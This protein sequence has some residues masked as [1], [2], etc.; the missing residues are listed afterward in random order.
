MENQVSE[1]SLSTKSDKQ[2]RTSS[3]TVLV[4]TICWFTI[5]AEGYDLGIYGAVLPSLLEYKEWD[6][7]PAKAGVIGSYA[8]IGMLLGNIFGGTLA[9]LIGRKRMLVYSLILFS[10]TMALAAMASSPEM[11][12]LYRFIGGIGLGGVLPS[13]AA[14]T[15]EYSPLKRRSFF[16]TVMFTGYS[17]GGIFAALIAILLLQDLGWRI[18]FWFGVIPL[19]VVPFIIKF[20]PESIGFLLSNNRQREAEEI[21]NR[22]GIDLHSILEE[23]EKQEG[24][25]KSKINSVKSLFS[26]KYLHATVLFGIVYF[27]SLLMVYGLITWLPKLMNQ[28]GYS[29]GSSISFLLVLNLTTVVG[30]LFAGTAADRWGSKRILSVSY[31]SAGICIAFLSVKLP[32]IVTYVLVGIAGFG[33]IGSTMVLSAYVQKFFTSENR[34]TALGLTNGFGRIGAIIGP[35]LGGI[36]MLWKIDLI[37]NFYIFAFVGLLAFLAV[38]LIPKKA[39]Q[40]I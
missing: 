26:K 24:S 39:N 13:V 29:L 1:V 21:A 3:I 18:M 31:L 27:M 6:M 37:W 5:F 7:S 40:K 28:A 2:V 35:A 8:L 17:V 25:V 22:Y 34:A 15:V 16:Y 10:I 11:F 9:D 19:L 12:G 23:E 4:I 36:L 14:L 33:T 32:L 20:L 30:A 38:V